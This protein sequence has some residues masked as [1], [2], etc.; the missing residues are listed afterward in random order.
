MLHVFD[1]QDANGVGLA[2]P[3][4][5]HGPA[6]IDHRMDLRGV[7]LRDTVLRSVVPKLRQALQG[8]LT[9]GR[10][11]LLADQGQGA[12]LDAH[13]NCLT[14]RLLAD[15]L[16]GVCTRIDAIHALGRPVERIYLELLVPTAARLAHLLSE[17]LCGSA[18]VTIAFC[19]LQSVLRRY[20]PDFYGEGSKPESGLRALLASPRTSGDGAGLQVFGLLLASE[21]F[22][23]EGWDAW[24]ERSLTTA[25]FK[26]AVLTQ[27]FDMIEVLATSDDDLDDIAAG[28]KLIRRGAPNRAVGVVACGPV[29]NEHPEL[30]RL[31]G[32]DHSASDPL[33][34]LTFARNFV[35]RQLQHRRLS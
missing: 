2:V 20:A 28:I 5:E 6:P 12:T 22:R 3:L 11:P 35:A 25:S 30:V 10:D 32:A 21:F 31:V 29:F 9:Q 18:E 33:A 17:D 8:S 23:R 26:D 4:S 7:D 15:D 34:S 16:D 27:W 19:N 14:D 13:V 1:E 24:T